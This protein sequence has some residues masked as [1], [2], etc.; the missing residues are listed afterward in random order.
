M[1]TLI[2]AILAFWLGAMTRTERD[3]AV[4][5]CAPM[6]EDERHD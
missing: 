6:D 5:C 2:V 3:N 4:I 1:L